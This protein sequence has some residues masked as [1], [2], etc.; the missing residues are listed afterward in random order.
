MVWALA[1]V[2]KNAGANSATIIANQTRDLSNRKVRSNEILCL[3]LDMAISFCGGFL[4]K[5]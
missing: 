1:G 2:L 3:K 4:S 5:R